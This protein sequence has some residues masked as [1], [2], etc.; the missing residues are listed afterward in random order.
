MS[1]PDPAAEDASFEAFVAARRTALLRTAYLLTGDLHDAEDLLQVA[2]AKTLPHWQRIAH[3]PEPYVRQVLSRESVTRWRARRWRET[4]VA[5]LP[6]VTSP[7]L[8]AQT[9][10]RL[11]L[12]RALATLSPRQRAVVVLRY[13]EDLSEAETSRL[14]GIGVGTVKSHARDGIAALRRVL[15]AVAPAKA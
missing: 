6:D 14:L 5:T 2:L 15:P 10:D 9:D 12:L 11:D 3:R 1:N 8:Q 4:A 13:Y 7:G